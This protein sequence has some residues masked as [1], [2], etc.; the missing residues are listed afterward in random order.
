MSDQFKTI[1]NKNHDETLRG[2]EIKQLFDTFIGFDVRLL[3][4]VRDLILHPVHV[5]KD[6][7]HDEKS[8]Y[9]GQVRL[10]V[11]FLGIQTILFTLM[12]SYDTMTIATVIT[13]DATRAN[14]TALLA[15][16]GFTIKEIN[17]ALQ[18]W[19]N[20]FTTPLN[21]ITV[22][23]FSFFFKAIAPKITLLGHAILFITA[24]NASTIIATPVIIL[25]AN[26]SSNPSL[27]QLLAAPIQLWFLGL[28]VWIFMSKSILGGIFKIIAMIGV[29]FLSSAIIGIMLWVVVD[30]LVSKKFTIGP[31]RY[32]I[33]QTIKNRQN[34]APP[35]QLETP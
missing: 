25:L 22:I 35:T 28:F 31:M 26:F 32:S 8:S 14:Y 27:A 9:L 13:D 17:T 24:N 1:E 19:F 29:W 3:A 2:P 30:T 4:T 18:G 12:K 6:A 16:E 33:Q 10:F 34:T 11:F 23:I 5:A 20:L 21:I 7:L 15:K